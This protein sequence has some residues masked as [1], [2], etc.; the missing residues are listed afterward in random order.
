M[1]TVKWTLISR[2]PSRQRS[3]YVTDCRWRIITNRDILFG[4]TCY[5]LISDVDL[6]TLEI[7]SFDVQYF[8]YF[9][10]SAQIS[11]AKSVEFCRHSDTTARYTVVVDFSRHPTALQASFV[12]PH[13]HDTTGCQCGYTT[14]L[15]TVLNEQPL[16]VQSVVKPGSTTGLTTTGL[17]TG[18]IHDTTGCQT[19]LITGLTAGCIV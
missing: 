5:W 16:F 4:G 3:I 15:T 18:C 6:L 11:H 2:R 10:P 14:G 8:Y 1:F 12:I 9:S 7:N 19:G 17:T 13:L